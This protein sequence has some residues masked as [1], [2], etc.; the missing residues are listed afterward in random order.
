MI[1][2]L[3]RISHQYC[4]LSHNSPEIAMSNKCGKAGSELQE[5]CPLKTA[6]DK[7]FDAKA[8]CHPVR[9]QLFD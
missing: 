5:M 2:A 9:T 1:I 8:V 3:L 7:R 4:L 6:T